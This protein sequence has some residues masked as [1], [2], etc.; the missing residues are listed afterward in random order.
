MRVKDSV[1]RARSYESRD[2]EI[3]PG[4]QCHL[5]QLPLSP[6]AHET[7]Q[8]RHVLGFSRLYALSYRNQG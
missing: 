8:V 4:R 6:G 2:Y 7:I 5:A 1:I 3:D